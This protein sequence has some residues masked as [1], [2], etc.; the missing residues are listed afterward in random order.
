MMEFFYNQAEDQLS[1]KKL[2]NKGIEI[3]VQNLIVSLKKQTNKTTT[4]I[5]SQGKYLVAE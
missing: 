5:T 3:K 1:F 2:L 4:N